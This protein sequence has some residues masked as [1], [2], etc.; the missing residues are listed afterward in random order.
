MR[1]LS[2]ILRCCVDIIKRRGLRHDTPQPR[3]S[4]AG[5]SPFRNQL[6]PLVNAPPIFHLSFFSM[7]PTPDRPSLWLTLS[8]ITGLPILLWAYKVSTIHR[9]K[10]IRLFCVTQEHHVI[11]I[12]TQNYIYGCAAFYTSDLEQPQMRIA[13]AILL[14]ARELK[15]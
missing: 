4:L 12:P 14:L 5:Q 9:P 10:V 3:F 8:V 6:S 2:A 13:Q 15:N 7:Q 11:Y 1:D